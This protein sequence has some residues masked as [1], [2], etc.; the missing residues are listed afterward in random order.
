MQIAKLI[1]D[2][3]VSNWRGQHCSPCRCTCHPRD[4]SSPHDIFFRLNEWLTFHS[5]TL[6][7]ITL[8]VFMLILDHHEIPI[9][10]CNFNSIMNLR[11]GIPRD[12][13]HWHHHK[14]W[15]SSKM[16]HFNFDTKF[17]ISRVNSST[18]ST[19]ILDSIKFLENMLSIYLSTQIWKIIFHKVHG[20]Q[21]STKMNWWKTDFPWILW[22]IE[23]HNDCGKHTFHNLI[24]NSGK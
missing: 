1:G 3:P 22:R 21:D 7:L 19:E 13:H 10:L 6:E 5:K 14:V 15:K 18:N 4:P 16:S 12:Y 20:K 17:K 24:K 9:V 11:F 8:F 23:L 2:H